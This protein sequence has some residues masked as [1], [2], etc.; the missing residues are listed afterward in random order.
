MPQLLLC[1]WPDSSPQLQGNSGHVAFWLYG[2]GPD[3]KKPRCYQYERQGE[4]GR[5]DRKLTVPATAG[6][7]LITILQIRKIKL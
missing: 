6:N 1:H 4:H 5:F 2:R 7:S 3:F